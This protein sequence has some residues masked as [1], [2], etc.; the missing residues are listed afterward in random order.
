MPLTE[1]QQAIL[2][3]LAQGRSPESYV[4]GAVVLHDQ[5][6]TPDFLLDQMNRHTA[7]TQ[8][9][10]ERLALAAPLSLLELKRQWLEALEQAEKLV[11]ALP[12]AELGCLYLD[13]QGLPVTPNPSQ[14]EFPSL[15][16]H[17][18]R[19]RGVWPSVS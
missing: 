7:F 1:F 4:A 15:R 16:R 12:A 3:L 18:G 14:K 8:E 19:V 13:E 9:E 17:F 5:G 10:V 6:F 2:R 11:A